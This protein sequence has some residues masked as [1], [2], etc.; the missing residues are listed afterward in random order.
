MRLFPNNEE[1]KKEVRCSGDGGAKITKPMPGGLPF[2]ET[3]PDNNRNHFPG[4]AL[5]KWAAFPIFA[6]LKRRGSSGG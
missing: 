6:A 3:F 4:H 5:A 1:Q 2:W